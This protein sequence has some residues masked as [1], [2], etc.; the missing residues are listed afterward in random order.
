[1]PGAPVYS[2][3][4]YN[5]YLYKHM[6]LPIPHLEAI[7]NA[8]AKKSRVRRFFAHLN[9]FI[10][11]DLKHRAINDLITMRKE[12]NGEVAKNIKPKLEGWRRERRKNTYI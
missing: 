8:W 7:L 6:D 10:D 9:I 2:G 5:Q 11:Y 1:M 4:L 12:P 3:A